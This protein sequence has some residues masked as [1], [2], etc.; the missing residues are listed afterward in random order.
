MRTYFFLLLLSTVVS[1]GLTRWLARIATA[2]GWMRS[3]NGD[4]TGVPRLG[5]I[6]VFATALIMM[7][8]LILWDNQV[9][10]RVMA[11]LPLAL[12]LAGAAGAVFAMGLYDDLR[13][14][15]PWQKLLVQCAAAAG[16]YIV[17]FRVEVLTNPFTQGQVHLGWMSLPL[18][19]LWLV[20]I[21][22]AFN[23]IDGLDGLAAGVGLFATVTLFLL[24]ML[25]AKS[26]VTAIT[27]A[28]AGALF[29]FLPHNFNPAR[30]YLGDSGSLTIGIVLAALAIDSSQKGPVLLTVAIPLMIFGLPLLDVSVTT[31]RRFLSGQ[32]LFRRDEEHLHHRLQ[33]I[34][35][36]PRASVLLL[37]GLAAL[38]A[39]A[40]L[41]LV[42]Y[43]GATAPLIALLCGIVAWIVVRQMQYAEFAELDSHVRTEWRSQRHVLRNQILLRK[44]EEELHVAASV[45]EAWSVAR[46]IIEALEFSSAA[47]ELEGRSALRWAA[48]TEEAAAAQSWTLTIPLAH[49]GRHIGTLRLTRPMHYRPLLFRVSPLLQFFANEF[50]G[51]VAPLL[52]GEAGKSISNAAGAR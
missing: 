22:N 2:R 1:F 26:F 48:G 44:A 15:K 32:P 51:R 43:R 18:T 6:S 24:A 49:E 36:T 42:N 13:G 25:Q 27:V 29:G 41:L 12:G 50:A 4:S 30:I 10:E 34:G 38:F 45:E 37:Y 14:A 40:S 31:A 47:C 28:L 46:R 39:L 3:E 9:A 8:L 23:L 20:A 35:M 7:L 21:S 52:G 5:G 16:L 11:E 17:G 33:K 19:L